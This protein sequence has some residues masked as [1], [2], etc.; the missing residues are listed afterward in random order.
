M[1]KTQQQGFTL[2]ELVVVIVL[3]AILGVTALGRFQDLSGNAETAA[4]GGIAAEISAA[5]ALNYSTGIVNNGTFAVNIDSDGPE[6]TA[7]GTADACDETALGNLFQS[8]AFPVGYETT[9][10]TFDC[11]GAGNG[12]GTTYL[13][14]I[15]RTGGTGTT[16]NASVICTGS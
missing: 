1:K 9:A 12:P 13:C 7:D 5:A 16:A 10:N 14:A 4:E 6:V 2:I 8:G 15:G 3:L 11:G